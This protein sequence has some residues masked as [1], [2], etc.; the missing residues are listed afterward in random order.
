[1]RLHSPVFS[2]LAVSFFWP[3]SCWAGTVVF[4]SAPVYTP[5]AVYRSVPSFRAPTYN[6]GR[7]FRAGPP[8]GG[9]TPYSHPNSSRSFDLANP[10]PESAPQIRTRPQLGIQHEQPQTTLNARNAE[11]DLLNKLQVNSPSVHSI[12]NAPPSVVQL[13]QQQN[14][15]NRAELQLLNQLHVNPPTSPPTDALQIQQ[16][17][18]TAT[19]AE[20]ALLKSLPSTPTVTQTSPIITI[21]PGNQT[22]TTV[23]PAAPGG[24]AGQANSV[25]TIIPGNETKTTSAQSNPT[26]AFAA[27]SFGTIQVFQNGKLIG[28]GTPSFAQ[29]YGYQPS[30]VSTPSPASSTTLASTNL[31]T[32]QIAPTQGTVLSQSPTTLTTTQAPSIS[33]QGAP[34][35][36]KSSGASP[37]SASATAP[38]QGT[39]TAGNP[40]NSTGPSAAT[41]IVYKGNALTNFYQLNPE[42]QTLADTLASA[43]G[44]VGNVRGVPTLG[45]VDEGITLITLLQQKNYAAIPANLTSFAGSTAAGYAPAAILTAAPMYAAPLAAGTFTLSFD[46]GQ[47]WVAPVVAPTVGNFIFNL[48]PSGWSP[49]S[50]PK[51]TNVITSTWTGLR[52]LPDNTFALPGPQ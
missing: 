43:G 39:L 25:V 52:T 7:S 22:K 11:T 23:A 13:Q 31:Q 42:G 21:V 10:W 48:D 37:L 20:N 5:P 36:A 8:F 46:L 32:Q 50:N 19:A 1:M 34:T 51:V 4:H 49:G 38:N 30:A 24:S 47:K 41:T 3:A 15:A 33:L 17:T 40:T 14:V 44:A 6:P 9:A 2:A 35:I 26:Y 12:Q 28:T 27:T 29:Q 16:K 18:A 45:Y